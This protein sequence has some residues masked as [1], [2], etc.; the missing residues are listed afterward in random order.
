MRTTSKHSALPKIGREK[1]GAALQRRMLTAALLRLTLALPSS[2]ST[3][4]Y[5]C[6][7]CKLR[8]RFWFN[9]SYIPLRGGK[10]IN[11][12]LFFLG[13]SD[14]FL[15][16]KHDGHIVTRA[17][18]SKEPGSRN[19][20]PLVLGLHLAMTAGCKHA[21]PLPEGLCRNTAG[22]HPMHSSA[23]PAGGFG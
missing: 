2:S 19:S 7:L 6:T 11:Q 22:E 12:S 1:S 14:G 4:W 9:D 13:S 10:S 21:R 23:V 3:K 5:K 17:C 20:S 18:V 8:F 15:V 16:F